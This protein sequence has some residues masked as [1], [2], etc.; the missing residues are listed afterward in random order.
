[1]FGALSDR[2]G[3]K[4]VYLAGLFAIL[5]LAFPYF[6]LLQTRNPALVWLAIALSLALAHGAVYG[7]QAAFFAECFGTGMR[8]SGVSLGLQLAAPIGGG[9]GP[10]AL[11]SLYLRNRHHQHCRRH[12]GPGDIQGCSGLKPSRKRRDAPPGLKKPMPREVFRLT[13]ARQFALSR[14]GVNRFQRVILTYAEQRPR[15]STRH[16]RFPHRR[17]LSVLF[18]VPAQPC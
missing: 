1:M 11:F 10:V 3:R 4:K 13:I 6:W 8:Y 2:V 15:H 16:Q 5:A 12:A 9:V 14:A 7:P 17:R 18:L